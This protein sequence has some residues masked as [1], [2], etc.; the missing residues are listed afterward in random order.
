MTLIHEDL[1]NNMFDDISK[2]VAWERPNHRKAYLRCSVL[3]HFFFAREI[4]SLTVLYE[5]RELFSFHRYL[6]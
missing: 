3:P 5:S 2:T 1:L 4:K 6:A